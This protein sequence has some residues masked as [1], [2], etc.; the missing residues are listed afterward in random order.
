M[1]PTKW[2][3]DVKNLPPPL[4]EEPVPPTPRPTHLP[5][6]EKEEEDWLLPDDTP[7]AVPYEVRP[8]DE[9][10]K[11][12][13]QDGHWASEDAAA[14]NKKGI[15]YQGGREG[16]ADDED[17]GDMTRRRAPAG[18]TAMFDLYTYGKGTL[19]NHE[20]VRFRAAV[21]ATLGPFI[22]DMYRAHGE[23]TTSC[24]LTAEGSIN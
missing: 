5:I 9:D 8:L 7:D 20:L 1:S 19:T 18:M 4:P 24:D 23:V 15:A 22:C 16:K 13:Q 21:G 10:P 12:V 14:N 2:Y 11:I 6:S 17:V 3:E